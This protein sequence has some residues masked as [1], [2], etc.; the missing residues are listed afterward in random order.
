MNALIARYEDNGYHD[1]YFYAAVWNSETQTMHDIME[2]TTAAGGGRTVDATPLRECPQDVQEKFK[3]WACRRAA[4]MIHAEKEADCLTP[5]TIKNGDELVMLRDV[6]KRDRTL[7]IGK[8][9]AGRVFWWKAFG[10]FYANG[11]NQ[12]GRKNIRVG[13]ELE[14]GDRVFVPLKATRRAETPEPIESIE[15]RMV[16]AYEEGKFNLRPLT[17]C[18]AWF[19]ATY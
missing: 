5:E 2:S 10:T 12:P 14:N 18:R 9:T 8:G 15:K 7:V 13:L 17:R 11:Y 19:S 16:S 4:E 3:Q 6:R 1:S